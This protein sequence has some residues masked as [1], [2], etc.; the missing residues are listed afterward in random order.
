MLTGTGPIRAGDLLT[1][2]G[3]S[4]SWRPA[5][6]GSP[7]R[8]WPF[9]RLLPMRGPSP[10]R[11]LTYD[12]SRALPL[13]ASWWPLTRCDLASEAQQ[14]AAGAALEALLERYGFSSATVVPTSIHDPR[15][16]RPSGRP[17]KRQLRASPRTVAA[18]R[19]RCASPSIAPSACPGREPSRPGSS[20]RERFMP[21]I[22]CGFCPKAVRPPWPASE[23]MIKKL[24]RRPPGTG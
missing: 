8:A 12:V 23:L 16:S 21:V 20:S 14:Q 3:M 1:F 11:K 9:S 15:A 10:R 24:R 13:L 4:A 7:R 5:W 18:G 2:Q 6:R 22:R 19:S 17:W